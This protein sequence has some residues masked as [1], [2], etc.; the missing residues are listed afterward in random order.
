MERS[1]DWIA[2]AERDLLHARRDLE[3]GF[4]EWAAFSAQQA[5]EKAIKA[6][7]LRMGGVAW[8][9]SVADLLQELSLRLEVQEE[10]LEGA[11]ALDRA[12]IPSRYPDAHP[13][14]APFGRYT[15]KEAE[16]L[17]GYAEF[18]FEFCKGLLS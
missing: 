11:L 8:G 12:Y 16:R 3:G 10:L 5:A 9:H 13:S 18:I 17:V 14:G 15:L 7:F 2:Q 6:V 4:Y 1:R